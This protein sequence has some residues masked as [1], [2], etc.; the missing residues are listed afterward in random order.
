MCYKTDLTG[1]PL[2]KK[3]SIINCN[4]NGLQNGSDAYSLTIAPK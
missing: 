2:N 3:A 4:S 1:V